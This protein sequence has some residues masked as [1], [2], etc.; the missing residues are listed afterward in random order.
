MDKKVKNYIY[1]RDGGHCFHCGKQLKINQVNID[2]Y[3][4]KSKGGTNDYF[5]IVLSCKRCNKYKQS[6][7]PKDTKEINIKLFRKAYKDGKISIAIQNVNH[8]DICDVVEKV[9]DIH[10]VSEITEFISDNHILKVKKNKIIS[11]YSK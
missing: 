3:Y 2:H 1:L 6:S 7:I 9:Y 5:N 11:I 8:K 10:Y 4:P